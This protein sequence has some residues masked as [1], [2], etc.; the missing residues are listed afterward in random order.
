MMKG[1]EVRAAASGVVRA[2]RD[3]MLDVNLREIG[4]E[5]IRGRE[6][7]NGVVIDHD[8]GWTTQY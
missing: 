6:G 2:T 5:T 7:G 1:V 8:G 3:G 4:P